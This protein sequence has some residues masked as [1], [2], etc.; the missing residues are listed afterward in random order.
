MP[1][2]TGQGN[3]TSDG[4]ERYRLDVTVVTTPVAGGMELAVSSTATLFDS[5]GITPAFSS[6]GSRTYSVP[7]GRTLSTSGSLLTSGSASWSYDFG[8]NTTQTVWGG[9]NRY[10][11]SGSGNTASVT[12]TATGSGSSF[13][14]TASVTVSNISLLNSYAINYN[15]NGGSGS[16]GST[17]TSTTNDSAT[18]TA[19]SG[20][21]F[22]RSGYNF[23]GW[24]TASNGTGTSYSAG[25]S[26]SL[27]YSSPSITLYA[28]WELAIP[29]PSFTNGI[30][31]GNPVRVGENWSDSIS[32]S[33]TYAD[34]GQSGTSYQA[35][36][37]LSGQSLSVVGNTAY[38]NGTI[39]TTSSGSYTLRVRAFGPGG[40][41]DT[42]ATVNVRQALPSWTDTTLSSATKGTYYSDTFSASNATNW[43]VSGLPSGLSGSGTGSTTVTISGTPSV[44]GNY[45]LTAI[46]YNSDGDAGSVQYISLNISDS[47]ISWSDQIL[48][49][50]TVVQGEAYSDSVLAT[51]STAITYSLASGSLP[52]GVT[53][54]TSTGAITGT[55]Q[56]GTENLTYNFTVQASNGDGTSVITTS[57]LSITVEAAGGYV[58]VRSNGTWVDG[59][60]YRRQSGTWVESVVKVRNNGTWTDSFSS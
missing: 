54:N 58:K 1:T 21:G 7:N 53:L 4:T 48:T 37:L 16:V 47:A 31:L 6:N 20:S 51:G 19:A 10:I 45:T 40:S 26:V 22:S 35:I 27:S 38:I 23:V 15:A 14:K 60:V 42:T 59:T 55:P 46:P 11:A 43:T 5:S 12:I 33:N 44:Y 8:A 28:Q 52:S 49:S 50:N 9:F 30:N 32:A 57:T 18:L 34:L 29:A 36:T 2:Y 41:T 25:S 56:A 17:T 3:F 24:N 13:L 39:G